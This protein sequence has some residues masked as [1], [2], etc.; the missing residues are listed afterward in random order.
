MQADDPSLQV[1]QWFREAESVVI[2]TGAGM[3]AESGIPTFRDAQNGLWSQFDPLR[4]ASAAAYRDDKALV[5]GWYVW[6]M[7]MVRQAQP[8]AGHRAL[9]QLAALK[10]GMTVVTQNVDDL[11]ERAGSAD[12]IH[13]HGNLFASRCFA[14]ARPAG[15]V[16]IPTC[17]VSEPTLRLP[18]PRCTHCDGHIRPGVVWFGE[19]LPETSWQ[20]AVERAHGCDLLLAVGTSGVVYPAASLP[21]IA[22]ARGA[23]VVEINPVATDL[24]CKADAVWRTTAGE[25]LSK[26]FAALTT[27]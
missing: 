10:P 8:H 6:R 27:E 3:S 26:L 2:L 5:W 15:D 14:C 24:S 11:H 7:A 12:A 20:Q 23:R 1:A 9:A 13:L 18:P 25:G 21:G 17:A 22:R 16:G 19:P 4:L